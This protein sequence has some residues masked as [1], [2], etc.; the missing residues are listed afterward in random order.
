MLQGREIAVLGAGIGG[1]A[2]AQA[3]AQRGARVTLL[4]Q[5][6]ALTEVGAGIQI[7]P[8]GVAVLDGLG[9]G[10]AAR[11]AGVESRAVV[12][13]HGPSGRSVA[14][15]EFAKHP[16]PRPYLMMHRADLIGVLEQGARQA[17]VD[18]CLDQRIRSVEA[19]GPGVR[20]T[21]QDGKM[22][23]PFLVGAD[24]LRS[25]TRALLNGA[26]APRFTGQV[27]WRA[28]IGA[29][30]E[31]SAVS[32]VE[33][34]PGRHL[35]RYPIRGGVQMNIVGIREQETWSEEGWKHVDDPDNLRAAFAGFSPRVRKLLDRVETVN[36][37]GL[38]R[39]PVAP[40]WHGGQVVLVG[41]AAHPTLPFLAQGANLALEDAW[42]LAACLD[43]LPEDEAL[44]AYQQRRVPRV[45]RAIAAAEANARNYHHA[46]P[47]KVAVGHTGLR[48]LSRAAPGLL[49][50][51]FDWLY[52]HDVTAEPVP[53]AA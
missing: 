15:M 1:L 37:W 8:N 49:L 11:R 10:A 23:V 2:V 51:K 16:Q 6:P 35:V 31:A 26:D 19:A 14:R 44:A 4:E 20:L 46:N 24:G 17:G 25:R 9:L 42:M 48:M 41:D 18:I 33:M 30:G 38:F 21:Q 12:L 28:V 13:R 5:A 29:G 27:A 43:A 34:G 32:T 45:S 3:L 36:I 22:T 53:Q 52:G 39:H 50:S 40:H 47:L 7:S